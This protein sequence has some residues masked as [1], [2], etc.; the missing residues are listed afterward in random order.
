MKRRQFIKLSSLTIISL[1]IP[2]LDFLLEKQKKK[3]HI[4]GIGG[5]G[6]NILEY[7]YSKNFDA[8]YTYIATPDRKSFLQG[9]NKVM[10]YKQENYQEN[11]SWVYKRNILTE[12]IKSIFKKDE[13]YILVAGLGAYT[14]SLLIR[15]L[16]YYL[17]EQKKPF[18]A[19]ASYPFRY[20]G[21]MRKEHAKTII[22]E[23]AD[24]LNFTIF[25]LEYIRQKYGNMPVHMALKK[26]D[27]MFYK[28]ILKIKL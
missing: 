27:E 6:G 11:K 12:S 5:A 13:Y 14:G 9:I 20:E 26:A 15:D 19:F 10:F 16:Y 24:N 8:K 2:E 25:N 28:E 22:S 1:T 21:K 7:I 3:I 23:I 18:T 4:I 17:S